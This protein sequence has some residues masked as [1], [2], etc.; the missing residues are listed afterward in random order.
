MDERARQVFRPSIAVQI[1]VQAAPHRTAT[2]QGNKHR[3]GTH[4]SGEG[5][6]DNIEEGGDAEKGTRTHYKYSK[7]GTC[8]RPS[9]RCE[10]PSA[11]ILALAKLRT[12]PP[13]RHR[14]YCLEARR[15]SN[16]CSP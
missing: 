14:D 7:F 12:P 3:G 11:P 5:R 9:A 8:A 10:V 13:P 16:V 15:N 1:A 4:Q 2:P 6:A